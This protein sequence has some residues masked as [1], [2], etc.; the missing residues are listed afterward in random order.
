MIHLR[1]KLE[2]LGRKQKRGG[3]PVGWDKSQSPRQARLQGGNW[4][5][6]GG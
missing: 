3:G 4:L 2:T 5:P 6:F 1:Q